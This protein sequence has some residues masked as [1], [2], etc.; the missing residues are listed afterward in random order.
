MPFAP[1]FVDWQSTGGRRRDLDHGGVH[2]CSGRPGGPSGR[3]PVSSAPMRRA[4]PILIVV[5]GLLA[6]L[7]DFAP[8]LRLPTLG[9]TEG[10]TRPSRRSSVWTSRAGFG[11]STG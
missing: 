8:G 5:I 6:L 7:I 3:L 2:R 10:G 9:D 4:G 11:S 1:G